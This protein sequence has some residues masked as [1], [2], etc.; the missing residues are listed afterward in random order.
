MANLGDAFAKIFHA[1]LGGN[2]SDSAYAEG[3][4]NTEASEDFQNIG[5]FFSNWFRKIS[6]SGLT[7][8]EREANK[9]TAEREDLAWQRQMDAAN[10]AHQ[11]EVADLQAS[12][13]NP[14][15]ALG[16]G[17]VSTP[18]YSANGSVS[19]GSADLNLSALFSLISLPSQL[20]SMKAERELM[21]ANAA[22]ARSTAGKNVAEAKRLEEQTRGDRLQNDYFET[23]SEL[24]KEGE[25]LD[26]S[27]KGAELKRI[28]KSMDVMSTEMTRNIEQAHSE[29]EKQ[30]LYVQQAL[31]ENEERENLVQLRPFFKEY[32]SAK[33]E[34][35]RK[36][37]KVAIVDEMYRQKLLDNK[38]IEKSL[39]VSDAQIK[40]S[41]A[42]AELERVQA[43]LAKGDKKAL[44]A[45]LGTLD[46]IDFMFN[47][48]ID[49]G[50]KI[51]DD[52]PI[53]F[54]K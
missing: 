39:E 28:W 47:A 21:S 12:G 20:K 44:L 3:E 14:M 49:A 33:S 41:E 6:G 11:R 35:S 54:V 24:R 40:V 46:K 53:V 30:L 38:V 16:R 34:E 5:N 8:A 22:A 36:L 23:V 45:E 10:T 17:G 26:N 4:W 32:Y 42:R 2:N 1:I 51:V 9:W 13:L 27:I 31:L 7:D 37:A 50:G 52:L 25:Q 29:Q 43:L 15:L 48:A 18:S 19:P